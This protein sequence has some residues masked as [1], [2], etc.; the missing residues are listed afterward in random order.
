MGRLT[1]INKGVQVGAEGGKGSQH[2]PCDN[3]SA[4]PVFWEKML[5]Y[6]SSINFNRSPLRK[7]TYLPITELNT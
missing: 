4:L 7:G 2:R 6:Y 1:E 3:G 5:C